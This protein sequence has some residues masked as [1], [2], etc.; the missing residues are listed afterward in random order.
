VNNCHIN[1]LLSEF[2]SQIS[3]IAFA[4]NKLVFLYIPIA[5]DLISVCQCH[6]TARC[7]FRDAQGDLWDTVTANNWNLSSGGSTTYQDGNPVVFDDT[8]SP[9]TTVNIGSAN[10]VPSNVTFNNNTST[11]VLTGEIGCCPTTFVLVN[12]LP[13]TC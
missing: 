6:N 11:Y 10:V 12:W 1:D 7:S 13:N 2:V 5:F 8:A 9:R 3:L 4:N